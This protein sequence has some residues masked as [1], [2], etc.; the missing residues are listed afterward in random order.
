MDCQ[1]HFVCYDWETWH[2]PLGVFAFLTVALATAVIVAVIM[3]DAG[4]RI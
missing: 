1:S 2:S 4:F 3:Y